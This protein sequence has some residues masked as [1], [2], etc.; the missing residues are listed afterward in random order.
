MHS[1]YTFLNEQFLQFSGLGFFVTLGLFL[2]HRFI[3]VY[4]VYFVC[5][6]LMLHSCCIIATMWGGPDGIE[7]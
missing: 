1:Q 6:C 2:V 4:L 7:A 3:C 5:F